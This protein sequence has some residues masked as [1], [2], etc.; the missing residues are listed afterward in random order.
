MSAVNSGLTTSLGLN[1]EM[2]EDIV[3]VNEDLSDNGS[4]G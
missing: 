3:G 4:G 1:Y 2:S